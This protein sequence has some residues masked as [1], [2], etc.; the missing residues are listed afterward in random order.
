MQNMVEIEQDEGSY[1]WLWQWDGETDNAIVLTPAQAL[2]LAY[3]LQSFAR[4][5]GPREKEI[6]EDPGE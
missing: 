5:Q 4:G 1:V 2:K 3:R 6:I